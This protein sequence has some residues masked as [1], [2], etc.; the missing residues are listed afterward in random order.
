[1]TVNDELWRRYVAEYDIEVSEEAVAE[2]MAYIELELRHRMQ[3]D[4]LTGG[5]PH[6]FP[7]KELEEQREAIRAAAQFEAKEPLVLKAIA[8]EQ[9]L[10]ASAEE[11]LRE[12]QAIAA[13]QNSTVEELKRFFGDDLSLLKRDVID[14]KAREWALGQM[15]TL[16]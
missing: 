1:M 11:L 4:R 5:E 2:E 10:D 13:R 12:A 8:A 9:K 7:G 3:Y 16:S 14:R 15:K 6:L